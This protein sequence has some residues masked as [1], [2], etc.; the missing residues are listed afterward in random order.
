M[1]RNAWLMMMLAG[2][3]NM[4]LAQGFPI[5]ARLLRHYSGTTDETPVPSMKMGRHTQVSLKGDAA[6][7]DSARA[8][9]ILVAADSVLSRY[10]G[11]KAAVR[12][13]YEPFFPTG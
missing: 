7:G 2:C 6:P 1:I 13:G 5:W 9:E 12:D 3:A 8:T 10:R 11:V 4:A